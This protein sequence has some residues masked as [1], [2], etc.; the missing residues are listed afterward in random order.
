MT[1]LVDPL[2]GIRPV[3]DVAGEFVNVVVDAFARRQGPRFSLVLSGGDTARSCYERLAG[4]AVARIDW[5]AVD[6]YLGDER[7]VPADHPDAN[8]RLVREALLDRVGPVGSFRPIPTDAPLQVCAAAYQQVIAEVLAGGGL[9]L[10]HLGLG[11]D[12]HTASLFPGS[13]S[14][15]AGPSELVVATRDPRGANPHP[16]LTLTLPAI[17][18]A[19]LAVFTVS[20][21]SKREAVSRLRSAEDLP[22][23]RVRAGEVRWLIDRGAYEEAR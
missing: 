7:W 16:R 6:V 1:S 4:D 5:A 9:D 19:R 21:P 22:A 11:P 23:A 3:E 17:A 18:A 10:V 13:D 20:G 14:L 8:Q 15:D 12:G 2:A